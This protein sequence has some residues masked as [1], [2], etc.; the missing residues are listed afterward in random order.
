ML[1]VIYINDL[2]DV[3]TNSSVYLFADDTKLFKY[4][5]DQNDYIALQKDLDNLQCWSDTWLLRFNPKKCSVLTI[6]NSHTLATPHAYSMT[7]D[8]S[9]HQL[10]QVSSERDLGVVIDENLSFEEHMQTKIN[11]ANR[12]MNL[13]RRTFVYLDK[14]NFS[15]LYKSL[16]RPHLEYAHAVWNPYL[17]KHIHALE[18][19]QRR[20]TRLV[21]ELKGFT[22]AQRLSKLN[23]PTLAYR[24]ARGDMIETY[25]IFNKYDSNVTP[26]LLVQSGDQTRGHSKK[27][28]ILRTRT[29][30]YKNSF[31]VRIRKTWNSLNDNVISAPSV[32]SFEVALD[33]CWKAEPIKFNYESSVPGNDP[34]ILKKKQNLELNIEA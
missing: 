31:Y 6:G 25:K 12:L 20:A 11:K 3:I 7:C 15:L 22:Y 17:K 32:Y 18:N 2:P 21:P 13:I 29:Q 16:V 8:G 10:E 34:A 24:R 28:F 1:F 14:E 19:V 26:N 4:I 5:K 23:I 9:K 30:R 27:L 33:R